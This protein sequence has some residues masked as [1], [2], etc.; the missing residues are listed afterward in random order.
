M[1]SLKKTGIAIIIIILLV[2][3]GI[4]RQDNQETSTI[5]IGALIP[6]SGVGATLGEW[7]QKGAISAQDEINAN[8]GINGRK[9]ELVIED[10]KCAGATGI[11]S[12]RKMY[13]VQKIKYFAGPLCAAVR[14]PVLKN[15]EN[16]NSLIITTGLAVTYGQNTTAKT[17]NVLPS[18]TFITNNILNFAFNKLGA[19]N[20]SLLTLDD[21]FGKEA[22]MAFISEMGKKEINNPVIEKFAKGTTDMRS[23]IVKISKDPNDF[24]LVVG[25]TPDYAIFMRQASELGLKK[26]ILALSP[27]QAPDAGKANVGTGLKIYYP[28]PSIAP[29]TTP[30][31]LGSG[32]DAVKILAFAIEKCGEDT[33][34][35]NTAI[36]S[37]QNYPG[38]NG[39]ITFGEKGNINSA[40]STE[41]RVLE[42]G[43]FRKVE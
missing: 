31:Y 24:V 26:T 33:D 43:E 18:A 39:A 37:L 41:I 32:Y 7:M 4:V 3:V 19:K 6:L 36:S 17:F 34:C 20:V 38:A 21:E 23:Q 16:D 25:F 27:I 29:G 12:Y 1:K 35:A 14:I 15:A 30:V 11:A 2:I 8:G 28:H 13:D 5:R 40:E 10:D 22:E 42:N 9:I